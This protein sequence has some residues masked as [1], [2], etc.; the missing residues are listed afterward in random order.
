MALVPYGL[1][2]GL[3]DKVVARLSRIDGSSEGRSRT[4]YEFDALGGG[5]SVEKHA[6]CL[7][8]GKLGPGIEALRVLTTPNRFAAVCGAEPEVGDWFIF[9]FVNKKPKHGGLP[10]W[11][12]PLGDDGFV[13]LARTW[14][15]EGEKISDDREPHRPP[16]SLGAAVP[17]DH[18]WAQG[19]KAASLFPLGAIKSRAAVKQI[20][21]IPSEL[22]RV[23]V[24]DVGQ[25]SF[26]CLRSLG[27][28]VAL[29]YDVGWPLP[30]NRRTEPKRFFPDLER[31][32][33]VI[34]HWDWDHL[35]FSLKKAGRH[36]LDCNW[37]A[38]VQKLGPGAA[39]IAHA[40]HA[41]GR[42][43]SWKG[44]VVSFGAGKIGYCSATPNDANNSGL[45]VRVDLSSKSSILLVGDADYQFLPSA[46][47]GRS[48][49]LVVTHHGARLVG[50]L[51]AV[52]RPTT[53]DSKC[54]I[55]F[56]RG[57]TY[58]HP[59]RDSLRLHR[60][61]GWQ[62]IETTAGSRFSFRSDK[63]FY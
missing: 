4:S 40:L 37:V 2:L 46:L 29:Y 51:S 63:H 58:K 41:K 42:L 26:S 32:P 16:R 27:G 1:D 12:A 38:P 3:P 45:A 10:V 39:R 23:S 44:S 24:R 19:I 15:G 55:S 25:A 35:C 47:T 7:S 34:S 6:S 14:I 36:L 57:N 30:F 13:A 61:A 28:S 21:Q 53:N 49:G 20:L 56:G 9:S 17:S 52:P 22:R 43:H 11:R 59:H 33:V 54:V 48:D 5:I 50:P 18:V 60:S 8:S 62:R 31:A